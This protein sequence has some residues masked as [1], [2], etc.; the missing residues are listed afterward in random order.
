MDLSKDKML[1]RNIILSNYEEPN[2]FINDDA[3]VQD[4]ISI[5]YASQTCIDNFKLFTKFNNNILVDAKFNGLGCAISTAS[6]NIFCNLLK[7]KSIE[8]INI[9][10]KNYE[11]MINEKPYDENQLEDLI[12]FY[13]VPNL[14][15]RIPCA[16][17]CVNSFKQAIESYI[18]ETRKI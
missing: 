4:Y 11:A 1:Y 8:Q 9:I 2:N 17:I 7:N 12:C 10:I 16:S 15:N 14:P 13:N 3:E 5:H 18:N 6:L